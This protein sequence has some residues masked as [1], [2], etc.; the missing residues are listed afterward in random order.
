MA[1]VE[2]TPNTMSAL[3]MVSYINYFPAA[4]FFQDNFLSKM[5]KPSYIF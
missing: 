5:H 4:Y 2:H 1:G 3:L